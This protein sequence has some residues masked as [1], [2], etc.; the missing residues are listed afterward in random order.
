M[1][2]RF[3]PPPACSS[4]AAPDVAVVGDGGGSGNAESS[5]TDLERKFASC[6]GGELEIVS[7]AAACASAAALRAEEVP[8]EHG[9]RRKQRAKT[10]DDNG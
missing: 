1:V 4:T 7:A 8:S 10:S 5:G 9:H 3:F 2:P 6:V